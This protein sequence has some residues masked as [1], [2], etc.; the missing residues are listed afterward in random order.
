[1]EEPSF[2]IQL[3]RKSLPEVE[4]KYFK[5]T[6]QIDVPVDVDAPLEEDSASDA[7]SSSSGSNSSI[8]S[9]EPPVAVKRPSGPVPELSVDEITGALYR[10]M[11]HV[12]MTDLA[13][14]TDL[15]RTACGRKFPRSSIRI[16]ADLS[17]ETGQSLCSH[18]GCRKGWKAIG[19]L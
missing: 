2:Q 6:E 12:S 10:N 9:T 7:G 4:W 8:S 19:A 15:I 5:F 1:M 13:A 16:L 14:D 11:W 3:F 18:V 17:L